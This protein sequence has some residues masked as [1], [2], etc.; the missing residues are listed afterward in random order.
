M[1][2]AVA[3]QTQCREKHSDRAE[4]QARILT[5][6]QARFPLCENPYD[7]IGKECGVSGDDAYRFIRRMRETG[8]IRR[9]GA[10]FNSR[11]MG[12]SSTLCALAVTN[13]A[14]IDSVAS[15]V[16]SY[17]EVTHNYLRDGRYNVWFTVIASSQERLQL[18]LSDIMRRTG[19]R[20]VLNLPATRL[21]KICVAF[22][23]TTGQA[24]GG[25][26][27][28]THNKRR[29]ESADNR[30]YTGSNRSHAAIRQLPSMAQGSS[31]SFSEFD[32]A[33]I[34]IMQG[35]ISL[36]PHPFADTAHELNQQ[37]FSCTS[38]TV[39]S[40]LRDWID[41]GVA[42]RVVAIIQHRKMGFAYNAMSVWDIAESDV[43]NAGRLMADNSHVS[44]CYERPRTT[45]WPTNMYAMIHGKEAATCEACAADIYHQ[46]KV[47]GIE[48]SQPHLLYSTRELKKCSMKYFC[49]SEGPAIG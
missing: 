18:I 48:T 32:R 5:Y 41:D 12:Y 33:L 13:P 2:Q 9:L 14:D 11:G 44:H 39:I 35:N 28:S 29:N 26:A 27:E 30:P 42:R 31:D 36:G 7:E 40:K 17:I 24:D 49:E 37:G 21:F 46:L 4:E 43:E 10:V 3:Q 19:Y 45:S 47:R 22:D 34:R 6:V 25:I 1:M 15:V 23:M 38:E 20:D 16:N 8:D